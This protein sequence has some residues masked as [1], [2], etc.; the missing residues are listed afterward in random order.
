MLVGQYNGPL[1][2]VFPSCVSLQGTKDS[3]FCSNL[4]S[5]T[6]PLPMVASIHPA[7]APG[8]WMWQPKAGWEPLALH[9]CHRFFNLLWGW[10]NCLSLAQLP[11]RLE[12]Y[13][14]VRSRLWGVRCSASAPWK[15]TPASLTGP[16]QLH[17]PWKKS[18]KTSSGPRNRLYCAL[19][20]IN[21]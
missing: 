12:E 11:G 20:S 6:K 21:R 8:S 19:K 2:S 1:K 13:P 16:R 9:S 17:L 7:E 14:G 3:W 5:H 4:V 15:W 10:A 18:V